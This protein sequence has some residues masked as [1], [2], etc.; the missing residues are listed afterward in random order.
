M[1][2]SFEIWSIENK[3]EINLFDCLGQ[4]LFYL[5]VKI[6]R[7]FF[8][9]FYLLTKSTLSLNCL[10]LTWYKIEKY[11]KVLSYVSVV[12]Y[13]LLITVHYFNFL[14]INGDTTS[15]FTNTKT[16]VIFLVLVFETD[17][18]RSNFRVLVTLSTCF[19]IEKLILV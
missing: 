19:F 1:K 7:Y 14:I 15:T 5:Y 4:D 16:N 11:W 13:L 6:K 8:W 17:K 3:Q 18:L 9:K 10:L 2:N 12:T